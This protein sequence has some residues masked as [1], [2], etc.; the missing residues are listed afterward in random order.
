MK[1]LITIQHGGNV[2]LFKNAIPL[3]EAAGH[4]I[5]VC[6]RRK[7][8]NVELLERYDI[9][10]VVLGD[11]PD[12]WIDLARVF[13]GFTYRTYKF[14]RE[15]EPDIVLASAGI[16][17]TYVAR[18]TDAESCIYLDT[19][20]DVAPG[21]RLFTPFADT[22]YTPR[23][24]RTEYGEKQIRYDGVHEL[25]Y[26]HPNQFE[27]DP[28]VLTNAG[29]DPDERFFVMRLNSWDAH[30]DIGKD[31]LTEAG[32][33]TLIADLSELGT[34]YVTHEGEL[35]SELDAHRL[36][37][38]PHQIHHLIYYADLF[39][40]ET[41]TMTVEAG[42]LGTPTI[43]VSPFAGEGDMG[44]F[45]A[46]GEIY[47]LV[48]SF[49]TEEESLAIREARLIAEDPDASTNWRK[50]RERLI[51]DTIDVTEYIVAEVEKRAEGAPRDSIRS[52]PPQT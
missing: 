36:P 2:H 51:E 14:A 7:E 27:P 44:K 39:V 16:S 21:V 26:L 19:E 20:P 12:G 46:L 33:Q 3:L 24:L 47:D 34:V 15:F 37:V 40:G 48:R 13:L 49:P 8:V 18:L 35:P 42:V 4:E 43:R 5:A 22:I 38:E 41:E 32:I 10:H 31:G 9:D 30:H 52:S 17:A 28:S 1:I 25:A 11:E 6:A 45:I 29:I 23:W 50:K